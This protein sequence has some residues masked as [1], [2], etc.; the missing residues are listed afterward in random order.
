MTRHQRIE[1][2][3]EPKNNATYQYAPSLQLTRGWLTRHLRI[4]KQYL[5]KVLNTAHSCRESEVSMWDDGTTWWNKY[6]APYERREIQAFA[7]NIIKRMMVEP[8][9]RLFATTHTLHPS[10]F[11]QWVLIDP[12]R[13]SSHRTTAHA[14]LKYSFRQFWLRLARA[15]TNHPERKSRLRPISLFFIDDPVAK[16]RRP[17]HLSLPHIHSTTLVRPCFINSPACQ[18]DPASLVIQRHCYRSRAAAHIHIEELTH[19]LHKLAGTLHRSRYP[20]SPI[21]CSR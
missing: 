17:E 14:K 2:L 15:H 9:C 3:V 19:S 6:Y 8:G 21:R 7:D 11:G 20:S 12:L 18:V 4:S 1:A 10:C 13:L 16:L 5:P